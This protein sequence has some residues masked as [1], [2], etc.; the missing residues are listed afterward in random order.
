MEGVGRIAAVRHRIGERAERELLATE[1]DMVVVSCGVRPNV[2]E[3]LAIIARG[4]YEQVISGSKESPII[5]NILRGKNKP[6]F[7]PHMDMGDN[8]IVI[9]ADAKAAHQSVIDVFT[10]DRVGPGRKIVLGVRPEHVRIVD[11]PGA[12]CN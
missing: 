9:N 10:A 6:T 5:A 8:V 7:T 11:A 1:A 12:N 4:G 2:D 3:A